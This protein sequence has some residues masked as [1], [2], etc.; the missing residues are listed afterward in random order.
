MRSF[1]PQF[2]ARDLRDPG[3]LEFGPEPSS[4]GV[5][6]AFPGKVP[7]AV[8]AT[9]AAPSCRHVSWAASYHH[10]P[11]VVGVNPP[12]P[13]V[14]AGASWGPEVPP[15]PRSVPLALATHRSSSQGPPWY[16]G[17]LVDPQVMEGLVPPNRGCGN[18]STCPPGKRWGQSQRCGRSPPPAGSPSGT[19][20]AISEASSPVPSSRRPAAPLHFGEEQ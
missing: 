2:P 7:V 20:E 12:G 1:R 14:P 4:S 18:R 17:V 8:R 6:P 16:H 13:I 11:S 15:A 5:W 19:N 9:S 10:P 3:Q